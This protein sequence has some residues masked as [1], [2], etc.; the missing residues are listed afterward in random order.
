MDT[1]P[2]SKGTWITRFAIRFFTIILA[3]LI[4]W[5]LGFF[6]KDIKSIRGP[7]YY[8]IERKHIDQGLVNKK[9]LL[10][11]QIDNL[12]R[13]IQ[14]QQER[15]RLIGD[16][17]QNLQQTINQL[18][19]L[20]KLGFQKNIVFSKRE[21]ANF[22]NSLNLF[23]ENQKKYQ[24]LYQTI[25]NLL[26]KKYNLEDKRKHIKQQIEKQ[27]GPARVEYDTL[28]EKHRLKL[29]FFQLALL[30]PLLTLSSILIIKKRLSIYFPFFLAFGGAALL[31]VTLVI[32]E[33]FP[34]RY[35]KYILIIMLLIV[36]ARLLFN[37]IRS[38]AFPKIQWLIKQYREAYERFLCPV[39]EYPIRTG[40]RRFLFWTR[41][42]VNKIIVP[43]NADKA[44]E[45]YTCPSCG[46]M[47]FEE[48]S[49]C[50]KVRH[51]LLPHCLYC[52]NKKTI[53]E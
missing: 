12:S 39:C 35:F 14:T 47:L 21:Q 6:V 36:V 18:L 9:I 37:F 33:Y 41:R 2:K 29:A 40:P 10:E 32:H 53:V 52:G 30:I 44:E 48:C 46:T 25:S 19:E 4:F 20:Q 27:R 31:K 23:L 26:Q 45:L 51:A 3:V 42:T 15:Q 22:T 28:S 24:K 13:Q 7:N 5:I 8:N 1:I 11:N 34:S 49:S 17:S 38:I 43:E 50:H 16:S